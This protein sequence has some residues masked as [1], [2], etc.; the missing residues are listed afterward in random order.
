MLWT[1]FTLSC[2]ITE[3]F[4]QVLIPRM[5]FSIFM[6]ACIPT[7]VSLITDYFEN[8]MRGRANS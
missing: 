3:N 8:E 4:V 7:S 6:S 5:L 1:T 2:A